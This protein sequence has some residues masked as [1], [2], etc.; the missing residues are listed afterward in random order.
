MP[1]LAAAIARAFGGE[2]VV[3]AAAAAENPVCGRATVTLLANLL[4]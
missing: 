2:F 4:F 3:A 1:P